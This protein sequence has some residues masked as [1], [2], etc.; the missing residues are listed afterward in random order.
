MYLPAFELLI[1]KVFPPST[2]L[3]TIQRWLMLLWV[4]VTMLEVKLVEVRGYV[5]L[6]FHADNEGLWMF[7]CHILWH[8][9]SGT[10]MGFQVLGDAEGIFRDGRRREQARGL[11]SNSMK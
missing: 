7:H 5:V 3:C 10:S 4:E 8:Q 2:W 11:C 9:A 1:V 6:R